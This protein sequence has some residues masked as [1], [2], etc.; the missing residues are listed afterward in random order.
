M[1]SLTSVRWHFIIV[2]IGISLIIE[3]LIV[4][5]GFLCLLAIVCLLW[6]N[7]YL[8]SG[9]E[10]FCVSKETANPHGQRSLEGYSS[11][12]H[13]VTL[14]RDMELSRHCLGWMMPRASLST[15][16]SMEVAEQPEDKFFIFRASFMVV[17]CVQLYRVQF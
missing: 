15:V 12:Q 6:R 9:E 13:G 5:C 2:L 8:V 4:E 1:D 17:Q 7:V 3:Y 11:Y 14:H 10:N 16:V